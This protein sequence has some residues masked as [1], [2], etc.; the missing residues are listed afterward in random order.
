MARLTY[1]KKA[2]KDNAVCKKGESYYWWQFAFSPK[3]LSKTK[4]RRSQL[5]RS[6]FLG[7]LYD[8]ED[9]FSFD[10][11]DLETSRDELVSTL[12][13]IRDEC[14]DS[15]DAMPD[16]LQDT[17][18]SGCTLTERI[19]QL[20]EWISNLEAVDLDIDTGDIDLPDTEDEDEKAQE[21]EE[22]MAEKIEEKVTE[23]QECKTL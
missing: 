5:T 23:L 7:Q 10:G 8:I 21:L 11:D 9:D 20:D 17:S 6:S 18:D 15:L 1:V 16:H 19:E 2:R 13:G 3:T 22:A 14:Q 4:P 12:E